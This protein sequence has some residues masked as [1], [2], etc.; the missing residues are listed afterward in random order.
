MTNHRDPKISDI[1]YYFAEHTNLQSGRTMGRKIGVVQEILVKKLLLTSPR[2][3]DSVV[4]EPKI[5]GRSG[6]THKVEFV[7]FQPLSAVTVPVNGSTAFPNATHI[8]ISVSAVNAVAR[9]AQFTLTVGENKIRGSMSE[10]ELSSLKLR[11]LLEHHNAQLRLVSVTD[12]G[13]RFSLLELE[14][15][16]LSIESKRVGA[17][18]FSNSESLGS[19]IQTIE[20]AKQ[21]SLVAIDFDLAFNKS[22]LA[23]TG[24][25]GK[26]PFRSIV[27][28][29]NGVHWKKNDVA[30]LE[31]YVDFTYLAT[32]AAIIRYAEYVRRKADA[33]GQPFK[34][35]F[36]SY[37]NGMTKTPLDDFKVTK[38]DFT[39]ICP[40][41]A[42]PLLDAAE[43]QICPYPGS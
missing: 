28:L 38:G 17:Q 40:E 8:K 39:V 12:T 22:I 16:K 34:D 5:R 10:G 19:G 25:N 24:R 13:A 7:F 4:Y 3:R 9:R 15:P 21:A 23:L 14:N 37:F 33:S 29:G 2:L 11:G 27:V 32:D 1:F 42:P 43:A 20:K 35:F 6:A 31:T 18:R 36:M 30:V 41:N 26:R